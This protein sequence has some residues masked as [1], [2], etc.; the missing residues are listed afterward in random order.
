MGG[1]WLT[2]RPRIFTRGN[3]RLSLPSTGII[4][5]EYGPCKLY[6]EI[7]VAVIELELSVAFIYEGILQIRYLG[8]SN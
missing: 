4:H 1:G 2:S 8:K 6:I 5:E 7:V 3:V